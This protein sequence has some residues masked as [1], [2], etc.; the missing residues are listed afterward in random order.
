MNDNTSEEGK[1]ND[2]P[3]L[4]F[5][6]SLVEVSFQPGT[7]CHYSDESNKAVEITVRWV[8]GNDSVLFESFCGMLKREIASLGTKVESV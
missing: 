1:F 8:F 3:A 2:E 4:G 6:I 7:Q 5:K